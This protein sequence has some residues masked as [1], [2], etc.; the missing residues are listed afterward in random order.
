MN[1]CSQARV[2]PVPVGV[3]EGGR[4]RRAVD[5]YERRC[6]VGEAEV[7]AANDDEGTA[8]GGRRHREHARDDGDGVVVEPG[9]AVVMVCTT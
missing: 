4:E 7:R 2:Q 9:T 5:K 8:V 6:V 1:A 3:R